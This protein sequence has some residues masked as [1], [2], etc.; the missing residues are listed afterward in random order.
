MYW[1]SARRRSSGSISVGGGGQAGKL[2][3]ER[4]ERPRDRLPVLLGGGELFLIWPVPPLLE[5]RGGVQRVNVPRIDGVAAGLAGVPWPAVPEW[6]NG[7]ERP[8]L[9]EAEKKRLQA[10]HAGFLGE[11]S[12]ARP[13]ALGI[14]ADPGDR[15]ARWGAK[16]PSSA[17]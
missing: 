7:L 15:P 16:L 11:L 14:V 2:G 10:G 1:C 6:R 5:P 9:Q 17:I 3:A 13:R 12:P 8:T 4:R